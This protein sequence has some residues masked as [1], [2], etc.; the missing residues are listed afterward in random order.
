MRNREQGMGQVS[1]IGLRRSQYCHTFDPEPLAPPNCE[2][3][4]SCCL[5]PTVHAGRRHKAPTAVW[6][7][8]HWVLAGDSLFALKSIIRVIECSRDSSI[9]NTQQ[10]L[11]KLGGYPS[12]RLWNSPA[13]YEIQNSTPS[14][15]L[16]LCNYC[17]LFVV[18]KRD[19]H[20]AFTRGADQAWM[21]PGDCVL[22]SLIRAIRHCT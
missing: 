12:S 4:N 21:A 5:N 15:C 10:P 13:K 3:I 2:R 7:T 9:L 8:H 14:C 16:T 11:L 19:P 1:L 20:W 6:S 18:V 22:S 17:L